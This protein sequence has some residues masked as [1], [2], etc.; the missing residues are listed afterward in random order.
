M[1]IL[2]EG[3]P[4]F[5]PAAIGKAIHVRGMDNTVLTLTSQVYWLQEWVDISSKVSATD[6]SFLAHCAAFKAANFE[7]HAKEKVDF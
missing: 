6:V 1:L 3:V 7:T 2:S 4:S 5:P